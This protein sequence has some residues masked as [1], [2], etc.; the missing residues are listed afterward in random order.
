MSYTHQHRSSRTNVVEDV[1]CNIEDI[2][3]LEDFPSHPQAF[4][5]PGTP[6]LKA[7]LVRWLALLCACS[8][9]VGSH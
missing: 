8:F 9:S 1:A 5:G 3:D 7:H 4:T 6:R 2:S